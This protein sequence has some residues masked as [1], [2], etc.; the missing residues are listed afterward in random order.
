MLY[1]LNDVIP[2]RFDLNVMEYIHDVYFKHLPTSLEETHS[3][4]I[5]AQSLFT[6]IVAY[7][8]PFDN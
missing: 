4:T 2:N 1:L 7:I 3:K 6:V 5:R 8:F